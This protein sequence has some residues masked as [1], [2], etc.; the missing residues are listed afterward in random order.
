MLD[1]SITGPLGLVTDVSLLK[2]SLASLLAVRLCPS[3]VCRKHHGVDK[4][5]WLEPGPL[6]ST[7]T[8]VVYLC[9]PLICNI[10]IVA[11]K[12]STSHTNH[13]RLI[14][15][16]DRPDQETRKGVSKT[17]LHP[18]TYPARFDSGQPDS[19]RGRRVGRG[20]HL[21]VQSP[22]HPSRGG[23]SLVGERQRI[24]GNMGG[25]YPSSTGWI[26]CS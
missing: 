18:H 4:M 11:G 1:N 24:Q 21:L 15:S 6:T 13:T 5:F 12:S 16:A 2:V 19:R 8:N 7:T 22:I 10:K 23:R 25:M 3:D 17:C 14:V 20:Q 9:R 26:G